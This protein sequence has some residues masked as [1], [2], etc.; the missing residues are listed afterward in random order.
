MTITKNQDGAALV[1][2]LEGRLDTTTAPELE[3]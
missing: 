1:I 3:K 2:A